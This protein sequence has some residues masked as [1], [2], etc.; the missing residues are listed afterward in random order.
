MAAL[1]LDRRQFAML[2]AMQGQQRRQCQRNEGK[3][4]P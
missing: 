4:S 3:D 2:V 1:W